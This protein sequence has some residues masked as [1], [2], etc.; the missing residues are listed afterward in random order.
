VE[1]EIF[2][3]A[4]DSRFL[5]LLGIRALGFSPMPNTPVLL[6][7]HNEA[8]SIDTYLKGIDIY[9]TIIRQL[10]TAPRQADENEV[11]S[12]PEPPAKKAKA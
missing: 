12:N 5:R 2:P 4:T 1:R 7:E 3:A 10:L 6:H 9:C 11:A 8:L